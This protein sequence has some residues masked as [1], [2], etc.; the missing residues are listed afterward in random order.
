MATRWLSSECRYQAGTCSFS[1]RAKVAAVNFT[2]AFHSLENSV[3]ALSRASHSAHHWQESRTR[4][5]IDRD[6]VLARAHSAL[7]WWLHLVANLR[8]VRPALQFLVSIRRLLRSSVWR[9]CFLTSHLV[10]RTSLTIAHVTYIERSGHA[11]G[12]AHASLRCSR[13]FLSVLH[14]KLNLITLANCRPTIDVIRPRM[15]GHWVEGRGNVG[16]CRAQR[17]W[18]IRDR[19]RI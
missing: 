12:F 11:L 6:D 9:V 1:R 4:G 15:Y 8:A 16:K 7:V 18:R 17:K 14:A 19:H 5:T 2:W 3:L 10:P 13:P